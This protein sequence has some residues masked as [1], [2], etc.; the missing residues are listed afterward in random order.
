MSVRDSRAGPAGTSAPQ[1]RRALVEDQ[2]KN[3]AAGMF[4]ANGIANTSLGDIATALGVTR[5]ALY[6]YYKSKDELLVALIRECA[7]DARHILDAHRRPAATDGYGVDGSV[8]GRLHEVIHRLVLFTTERPD[9]VRLLDAA[10]ELEP[11]AERVARELNRSFFA[12]FAGLIRD[13]V[14]AGVFREVDAGV[15]AHAIVGSTRSV[16]WWF[17]PAGQRTADE[18]AS[19]I[20]DSAVRGLLARLWGEP[21]PEVRDA[22]AQLRDDVDALTRALRPGSRL[23]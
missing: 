13:G 1:P 12:D 21:P 6:H 4:L 2:I 7:A 23:T 9:R 20:A 15:A 22:V 19:Q 8:A 3:A 5:T 17:D 10:A 16:A 18:V 11:E 14:D